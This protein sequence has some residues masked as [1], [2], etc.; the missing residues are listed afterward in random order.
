VFGALACLIRP[1]RFATAGFPLVAVSLWAAPRSTALPTLW[2][3]LV[4]AAYALLDFEV[5]LTGGVG[6]FGADKRRKS[7]RALFSAFTHTVHVCNP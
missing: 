5:R 4:L 1:V 3:Q 7:K 6:G 2:L